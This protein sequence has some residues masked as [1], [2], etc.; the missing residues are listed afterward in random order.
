MRLLSVEKLQK[1][2]SAEFPDNFNE[3][4]DNISGLTVRNG[5]FLG[6]VCDNSL[7][8]DVIVDRL[9]GYVDAPKV[10]K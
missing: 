8:A 10:D 5:S 2:G 7:D 4:H 1:L 9:G 3:I 6:V